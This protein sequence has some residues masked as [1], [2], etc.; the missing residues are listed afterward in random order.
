MNL[1]TFVFLWNLFEYFTV[2]SGVGGVWITA[3]L[4]QGESVNVGAIKACNIFDT[5]KKC[6]GYNL[7]K[8][9]LSIKV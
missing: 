8:V 7:K 3:Q 6:F 5:V 4:P 2:T 9:E 1:D